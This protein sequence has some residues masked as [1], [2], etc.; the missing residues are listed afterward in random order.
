MSG[1]KR[2]TIRSS[3]YS[4]LL[5][6]ESQ[7]RTIQ[8]DLPEVLAGM[9]RDS[10]VELQRQLEP[11]AQRHQVLQQ[12][13]GK[14]RVQIDVLASDQQRRTELAGAWIAMTETL[15]TLID[16]HYPHRQFAPGQL[17]AWTQEIQQARDNLAQRA[18][19]AAVG[20]AQRTYRGLS[21]LRDAL[22]QWEREWHMQRSAAMDAARAMLVLVQKNYQCQAIDLDGR[23]T[24][25]PIEVD[26]WADGKL[27]SLEKAVL[28]L[29]ARIRDE[30]SPMTTAELQAVVERTV[31]ELRRQLEQ[32]IREARLAALGSQLRINIADLVVQALEEKGFTVQ[33]ST[34]DGEDLRNGYAAKVKHLDGSEIVVLVTPSEEELGKNDMRIHSFDEAQLTEHELYQRA[35]EINQALRERGLEVSEPQVGGTRADPAVRDLERVRKRQPRRQHAQIA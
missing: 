6:A 19:E 24:S 18:P 7:L 11:L 33:D 13:L 22:E 20:V 31:P 1:E 17:D 34:Y 15:H 2:V 9:W 8:W 27:I 35:R 12:E 28:E 16:S 21:D 29:I 26:W 25:T 14:M 3:E 10:S 4:R 30:Q 23:T 5:Q 32:V